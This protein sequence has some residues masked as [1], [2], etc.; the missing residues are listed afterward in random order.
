MKIKLSNGKA[1]SQEAIS[2][3][4]KALGFP[5]SPSFRRFV[6]LNDGAKPD[7]RAFS[8]HF[9]AMIWKRRGLVRGFSSAAPVLVIQAKLEK[10]GNSPRRDRACV[11]INRNCSN[12]FNYGEKHTSGVSEF[13]PVNQIPQERTFVEN[14]PEKAYPVAWAECGDCIFINEA[15]GGAVFF[16]EHETE[17]IIEVAPSFAAF[18]ELLEPFDVNSIKLKPGQVKRVW[19]DPGFLKSQKK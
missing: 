5:L 18:L 1:A 13:I 15:R 8:I 11:K 12:T 19:V 16:W 14:L 9:D 6:T 7:T 2:A 10:S 4:E 3:V 17:E